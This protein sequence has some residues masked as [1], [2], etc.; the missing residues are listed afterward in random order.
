MHL[1]QQLGLGLH[2]F[3]ELTPIMLVMGVRQNTMVITVSASMIRSLAFEMSLSIDVLH[4]ILFLFLVQ[5][6]M[7]GGIDS[8]R[9]RL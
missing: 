4:T 3:V 2:L 7:A 5:M 9:F 1:F 6:L 8:V